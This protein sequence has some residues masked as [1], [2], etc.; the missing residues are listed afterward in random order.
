MKQFWP[1]RSKVK[2]FSIQNIAGKNRLKISKLSLSRDEMSNQL[3]GDSDEIFM[4][5]EGEELSIYNSPIQAIHWANRDFS[6]Y[7]RFA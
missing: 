5:G 1:L 2:G 6:E 4:R 3:L 7:K